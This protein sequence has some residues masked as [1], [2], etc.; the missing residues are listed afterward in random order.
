V[1]V[2]KA[3]GRQP[4]VAKY[5]DDRADIELRADGAGRCGRAATRLGRQPCH[6]VRLPNV[7]L[8]VRVGTGRV[9]YGFL[10]AADFFEYWRGH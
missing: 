3:H 6:S 5:P 9:S 2:C 4:G 7:T 8:I 10:E 1:A